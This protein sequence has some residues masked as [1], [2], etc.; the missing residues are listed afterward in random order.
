MTAAPASGCALRQR[1]VSGSVRTDGRRR[2]LQSLL[3]RRRGRPHNCVINL[4]LLPSSSRLPEG[5]TKTPHHQGSAIGIASGQRKSIPMMGR[6]T[7]TAKV[8]KCPR[9]AKSSAR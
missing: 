8:A 7:G 5:E 9:E 3:S 4:T 6:K 1:S 2:L